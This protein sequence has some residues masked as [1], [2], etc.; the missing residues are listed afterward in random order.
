MSARVS[1]VIPTYNRRVLV[2]EAIQSALQQTPTCDEI[3]VVD[4][5]STDGTAESIASYEP[6]VRVVSS[7]H[8]GVSAARNAGLWG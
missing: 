7:A 8:S 2:R 5:G 3:L 4:D 1:V 6:D